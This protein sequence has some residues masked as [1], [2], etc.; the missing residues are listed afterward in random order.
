MSLITENQAGI[1]LYMQAVSGN[2][3]DTETFKKTLKSHLKILKSAY[4]NTYFIGDSALYTEETIQSLA[5]QN[6]L[7]ITL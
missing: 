2:V 5:E 6:Q 1:P 7:F 3:N 4:H